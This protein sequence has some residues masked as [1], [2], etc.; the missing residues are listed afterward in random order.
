MCSRSV[1]T[2]VREVEETMLYYSPG[3]IGEAQRLASQIGLAPERIAER[4]DEQ[5]VEDEAESHVL[6]LLGN[7]W[8]DVTELET[9]EAG[10][11]AQNPAIN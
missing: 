5:L 4:P 2:V 8:R 9:L 7:D 10:T 6:L 11:V 1:L 3:R